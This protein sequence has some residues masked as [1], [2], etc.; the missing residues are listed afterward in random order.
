MSEKNFYFD[1]GGQLAN[2]IPA[3]LNNRGIDPTV[4]LAMSG[5][6]GGMGGGFGGL[7]G[8]LLFFLLFGG[9]YGGYGGGLFGGRGFGNGA[10]FVQNDA[11][12]AIVL[13]ALE[14][15]GVNIQGIANAVGASKDAMMA[16][17]N[18]LSRELCNYANNTNQNFNQVLTQMLNGNNQI[19]GQIAN[20]CCDLKQLFG[21]V[22]SQMERQT[23]DIERSIERQTDRVIAGQNEA[24]FAALADKLEA[25]RD[26]NVALTNQLSQEHQTREIVQAQGQ[27]LNPIMIKLNDF[28]KRLSDIEC[29]Q[30]PTT[31]VP[32]PQVTAIPNCVAAQYGFYGFPFAGGNGSFF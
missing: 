18:G 17:I 3:I 5:G 22:M 20:C 10:Q 4:L 6:L 23:C 21:Q 12:T 19:A 16:A 8:L 7:F 29:K 31:V 2:M 28:D 11:N 26:K 24:R 13:Q 1:S 15:N 25:E 14:R 30:P 9:G 27:M 32:N